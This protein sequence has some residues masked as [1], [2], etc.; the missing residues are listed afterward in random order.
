M[1]SLTYFLNC[2]H[3][4]TFDNNKKLEIASCQLTQYIATH[5]FCKN[6]IC[7]RPGSNRGPSVCQTDVITATPRKL[8]DQSRPARRPVSRFREGERK[9]QQDR[10][11]CSEPTLHLNCKLAWS[12]AQERPLSNI[13][14]LICQISSQLHMVQISNGSILAFLWVKYRF[15]GTFYCPK[16]S[17]RVFAFYPLFTHSKCQ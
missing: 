16:C 2:N 4:L 5:K 7:F 6:I 9:G 10:G 14:I 17:K 12:K 13:V 8:A 11:R 3:F 15:Q 1:I